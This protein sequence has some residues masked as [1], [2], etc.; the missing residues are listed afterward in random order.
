VCVLSCNSHGSYLIINFGIICACLQMDVTYGEILYFMPSRQTFYVFFFTENCY[1]VTILE[2][3]FV[4]MAG[5]K[6]QL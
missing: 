6:V 2:A 5:S 3:G 1:R 4:F